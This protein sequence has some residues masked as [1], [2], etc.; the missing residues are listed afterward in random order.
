MTAIPTKISNNPFRFLG[1]YTSAKQTQILQNSRKIQ[2]FLQV[3]RQIDFET[4]MNSWLPKI[5]RSQESLDNA[6]SQIN[7]PKDKLANALFW[8]SNVTNIDEIALNHLIANNIDKSIEI[9]TNYCNNRRKDKSRKSSCYINLAVIHLVKGEIKEAI[10]YYQDLC[11]DKTLRDEFVSSVCGSLLSLS[12]DEFV[13]LLVNELFKEFDHKVILDSISDTNLYNTVS[14]LID[15]EIV[16]RIEN[17]IQ[18]AK[19]YII[20][21]GLLTLK[22]D[23]N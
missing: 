23:V 7:L 3:G 8:F 9:Y 14:K 19:K 20:K 2:A 12:E 21:I 11:Y 22:L 4:D 6:L 18:K 13:G 16:E 10:Y 17:K 15:E 1:I 5:E